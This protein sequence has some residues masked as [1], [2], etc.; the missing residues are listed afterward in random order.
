MR[1]SGRISLRMCCRRP[2]STRRLLLAGVAIIAAIAG[3]G[4]AWLVTAYQFPGRDTLAWL[5]PL[6]LA[7][8][9]Y[10]VA[11]VYVDLLDAIGPVQTCF[12]RAD[13]LALGRRL[14]V[15]QSALAAGRDLRDRHRALSLRLSRRARDVPDPKRV[16]DR[17]RAHA[18]RHALHAGAACRAAPRAARARGRALAGAARDAQRHRRVRISRRA[19][20]H[21]LDL[22]HL[23]QPRKPPRRGAD[24]LRDAAGRHRTDGARA[25][26]PPPPPLRV[27]NAPATHLAAHAARRAARGVSRSSPARC[28]WRSVSWCPPIYLVH[29]VIARGLLVGFD[30]S[31]IRHTITTVTLSAIATAICVGIGLG[32][33]DRGAHGA[34]PRR[35]RLPRDRGARLCHSRHRAG[36]RP[37]FAARRHRRSH[38]RGDA[39]SFR[40]RRRPGGGGLGRGAGDR[41]CAA[42]SRHRHRLGASRAHPHLHAYGRCRAHARHKTDGRR[43]RDPSAAGAAGA[44]RRG[45]ACVRGLPEGIARDACCCGRSMSKRCRPT[46]INSPPAAISRKA[47]SR[48]CSLSRSASCPSFA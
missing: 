28:R 29:E 14:L 9:T 47:R 10:I 34:R 16:D 24:R 31:L 3:T 17:G 33:R 37:A 25:S 6:P 26:W 2:W 8:P 48:P 42:L 4:T 18:R 44:R 27:A 19:H 30:T 45:V 36:A 46:F 22:H 1:T 12:A 13:R 11:Y 41:L 38:Q 35:Q 23:A 43:A 32:R 15:S 7:I 5:L 20:A 21:A 39:Q 40:H